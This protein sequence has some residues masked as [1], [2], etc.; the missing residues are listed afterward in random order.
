MNLHIRASD[1]NPRGRPGWSSCRVGKIKLGDAV[2]VDGDWWFYP[3]PLVR[4]LKKKM[5]VRVGPINELK[6][7]LKELTN[8][9][10]HRSIGLHDPGDGDPDHLE[11]GE[12]TR[13]FGNALSEL[14][15]QPS[16][17]LQRLSPKTFPQDVVTTH[18]R[19]GSPLTVDDAEA[20]IGLMKGGS[21]FRCRI[22]KH[23]YRYASTP[24]EAVESALEAVQ[25][26]RKRPRKP[27]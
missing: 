11:A 21:C 10:A 1:Y 13:N 4:K 15:K 24:G 23:P 20:V 12:M 5:P 19:S 22:G 16:F 9:L 27:S 17:C 8:E 14:L 7:Y 26:P 18:F 3:S 6:D 2:R 25:N